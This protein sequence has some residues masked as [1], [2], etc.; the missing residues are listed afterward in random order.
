MFTFTHLFYV[1][2]C[3]VF[4]STALESHL[5][6]LTEPS[7]AA[8]PR[9]NLYV[10]YYIDVSPARQVE[11]D[12]VLANNIANVH[13]DRIY[14]IV[15]NVIY[16]HF[17]QSEKVRLVY[18]DR[19]PM[20][21]DVFDIMQRYSAADEVSITANTDMYYDDTLA[22]VK[23]FYV[24]PVNWD[25]AMALNRYDVQ[26]NG[27]LQPVVRSRSQDTWIIYGKPKPMPNTLFYYGRWACDNRIMYELGTAGYTVINPSLTV[28]T[29]HLH[30]TNI[31]RNSDRPDMAVPGPY[32]YMERGLLPL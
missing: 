8:V 24:K 20:F 1:L 16:F 3:G 12:R 2:V 21:K 5:S 32:T 7:L 10:N 14:L 19:R 29:Y 22:L 27:M 11:I 15:D 25:T 28:I 6:T 31:R 4:V 23:Q 9:I 17:L 26:A 13:I 30:L 18:L